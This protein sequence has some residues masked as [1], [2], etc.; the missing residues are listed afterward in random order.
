MLFRSAY[1]SGLRRTAVGSFT[2]ESAVTLDALV[3]LGPDAARKHLLPVEALVLG[4]PRADVD[5]DTAVR[6]G[7]GQSIAAP[8]FTE[9][10]PVAVF[11]GRRFLGVGLPGQERIAPLRLLAER[12][13][14]PDFA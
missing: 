10:P 8:G 7:H 5:N 11:E 13:K 2:L 14:S 3:A 4:L 12:P 6:F 1:L 9:G